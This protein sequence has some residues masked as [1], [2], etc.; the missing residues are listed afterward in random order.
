MSSESTN[1]KNDAKAWWARFGALLDSQTEWPSDYLFKFIVPR[2]RF[3]EVKD[4]FDGEKLVVR[5]STRGRYLSVTARVRVGSSD[6]VIA[7]YEAA[8]SIEGVI[9]L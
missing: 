2:Q 9:S 4:V 1:G 6:D 8:G 3:E 5:A 7:I